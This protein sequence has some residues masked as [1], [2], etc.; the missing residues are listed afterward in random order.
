MGNSKR[1]NKQSKNI[2]SKLSEPI[3][4][5]KWSD[6]ESSDPWD[7]KEEFTGELPIINSIGFLIKETKTSYVIAMSIDPKN[8]Q[9][10]LVK[11][12]PKGMIV[13]IHYLR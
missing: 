11:T 12:I 1:A 10:C 9:I 2:K 7:D 5:I 3:V 6:C 8:E 13:S 4:Y